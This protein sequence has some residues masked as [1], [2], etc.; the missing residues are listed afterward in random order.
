ML[1]GNL[2]GFDAVTPIKWL[3]MTLDCPQS[4]SGTANS[5]RILFTNEIAKFKWKREAKADD[6]DTGSST[7]RDTTSP[8]ACCSGN[9]STSFRV[10]F[11]NAPPS[12]R[13]PWEPRV[14][15]EA[16][17]H[18][19]ALHG[20]E[21]FNTGKRLRLIRE[22]SEEKWENEKLIVPSG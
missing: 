3:N 15:V 2:S 18:T 10:S 6:D 11:F 5:D 19:R 20:W 8:V 21:Q 16:R 14:W 17:R 13:F 12:F 4:V 22:T 9:W 1:D 7:K